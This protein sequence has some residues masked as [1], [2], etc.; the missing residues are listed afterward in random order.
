MLIFIHNDRHSAVNDNKSKQEHKYN[1][2]QIIYKKRKLFLTS[3]IAIDYCNT[4]SHL[5]FTTSGP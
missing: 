3:A 4:N 1:T 2:L 5:Y